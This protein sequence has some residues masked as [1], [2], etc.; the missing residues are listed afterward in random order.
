[1]LNDDPTLPDLQ[2]QADARATL[3][4]PWSR[5]EKPLLAGF[6]SS[7]MRDHPDGPWLATAS[8]FS[9]HSIVT[10]TIVPDASGGVGVYRE[11]YSTRSE[12]SHEHLSASLGITV[13]YPFLNANVTGEY[14]ST[15]NKK[16]NGFQSSRNASFRMGRVVLDRP[17]DFSFE[18]TTILTQ[19]DGDSRFQERYGNYYVCG[20]ELGADAGACISAETSTYDSAESFKITVTVKVL[21]V[22]ASASHTEHFEKHDSSTRFTFSG[23]STL[24]GEVKRYP[25]PDARPVGQIVGTQVAD[26][27]NLQKEASDH[28]ARVGKLDYE[29]QERMIKY[30]LT[31]GAK[32]PLSSCGEVCGSGLVVQLL[33]APFANLFEYQ[34]ICAKR[35]AIATVEPRTVPLSN[36]IRRS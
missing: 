22:S 34:T 32:L 13:G 28:V 4:L 36:K 20:Y 7:K 14:D 12:S 25:N 6:D 26:L 24:H 17:P 29:L 31:G 2:A 1:M 11:G 8:P 23:F 9:A 3:A 10:A 18:A 21:F 5:E 33:L 27:I 19:P 15:V 16:S 30:G 35:T